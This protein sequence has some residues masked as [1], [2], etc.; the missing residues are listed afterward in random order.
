MWAV[1]VQLK[2]CGGHPVQAHAV[3]EEGC[4]LPGGNTIERRT[5][6]RIR[7]PAHV[8]VAI[9][10]SSI[11]SVRPS[12]Q[13]THPSIHP[14]T[15]PPIHPSINPAIHP[16]IHPSIPHDGHARQAWGA[17]KYTLRTTC[18]LTSYDFAELREHCSHTILYVKLVFLQPDP[19]ECASPTTFDFVLNSHDVRS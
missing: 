17:V 12:L 8:C 15:H 4:V 16:P 11:Q 2:N 1:L 6:S 13:P 19:W 10:S 7:C 5:S 14:S 9:H 3:Q 18:V